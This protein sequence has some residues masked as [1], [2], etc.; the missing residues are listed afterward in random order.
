[1]ATRDPLVDGTAIKFDL[2]QQMQNADQDGIPGRMI[3]GSMEPVDVFLAQQ[4]E[5]GQSAKEMAQGVGAM[6]ALLAL[7]DFLADRRRDSLDERWAQDENTLLNFAFKNGHHYVEAD[8]ARRGVV[9]LPLPRNHVRR[10]VAKFEPWYR[11]QHGSLSTQT[12]QADVAPTSRAQED[13]DAASYGQNLREWIMPQAYSFSQRSKNAMWMLLGGVTTAY[14][15]VEWEEDEEYL[16]ATGMMHRPDLVFE[17]LSPMEVWNANHH[18]NVDEMRWFG[19]DRFVPL[20]EARAEY[21]DP[22]QQ[23]QFIRESEVTDPTEHGYWTLRRIQSLLGREDPWGRFLRNSNAGADIIHRTEQE[24]DVILCEYWGRKNIV[25]NTTH[26]AGLEMLQEEGLTVEVL[27][28]QAE[29]GTEDL[30]RFPNGLRIVFTPEGHILEI[31]DNHT[32][33]GELPFREFKLTQSAGYWPM[34][35][36]TPLREIN[37]AI[38]WMI[39]LRE[40]HTIRVAN[41]TFLE[42]IEARVDRRATATGTTQRIRYRANRF[43]M[44]PEWANPPSWPSDSVQYMQELNEIWME[45]SGRREVS[46]GSLPA[47]LSGVAVSLLQE[48]DQAQLTFAGA[49]LED[50]HADV[51]QKALRLVQTFFP[52]EDPRL[53]RI[54]G[55]ARFKVAA[56]MQADLSEDLDI[57]VQK[58]SGL[59]KQASALKQTSLELFQA[60]VLIDETTGLPDWRRVMKVFEFGTEDELYAEEELDRQN[61]MDEEELI[62]QLPELIAVELLEISQTAGTLPPPINVSAFDNHI[63]HEKSHRMRLKRIEGDDRI[64]DANKALLE[65]H[66]SLTVMGALPIL[67]NTDPAVVAPFLGTPEPEEGEGGGSDGEG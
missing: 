35:W 9:A 14:I 25:L 54:A 67:L 52:E 12:P 16:E 57:K 3:D 46:Q 59:P 41:P 32:P 8:R 42:P 7:G 47:R 19:R 20:P 64:G 60:G 44:K 50:G 40:E 63:V 13:R 53:Q 65:L 17:Y 55:D 6:A 5:F 15:G 45:I 56:F 29:T 48:A 61:A 51:L 28:R 26:L 4:G 27:Q 31:K 24:E 58:G 49:E 66:W 38:N 22:D 36:A 33:G 21:L 37:Q 23:K 11:A 10:K 18:S 2:L 43:N 1:M 62:L 39:S 34:A 30:V